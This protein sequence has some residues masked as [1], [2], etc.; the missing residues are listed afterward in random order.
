[1][2]AFTY[3]HRPDFTSRATANL[4]DTFDHYDKEKMTKVGH[5]ADRKCLSLSVLLHVFHDHAYRGGL[6]ELKAM[7]WSLVENL[8]IVPYSCWICQS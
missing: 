1:M 6:A 4:K 8:P 3:T 5:V 2:I 7:A